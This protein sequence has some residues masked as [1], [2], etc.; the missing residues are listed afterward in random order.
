MRKGAIFCVFLTYFF[1]DT[2]GQ[3]LYKKPKGI[4]KNCDQPVIY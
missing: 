3:F 2:W 1:H 4:D